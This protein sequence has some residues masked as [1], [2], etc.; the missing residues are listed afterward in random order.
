MTNYLLIVHLF[1]EK[2]QLD[3][4]VLNIIQYL[5]KELT[6]NSLNHY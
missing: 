3:K 2:R 6:D 4:M 5:V 1:I